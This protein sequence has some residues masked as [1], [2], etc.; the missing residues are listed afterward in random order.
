M[1]ANI[2]VRKR[3][4]IINNL[5]I[6]YFKFSNIKTCEG[7]MGL[8]VSKPDSEFPQRKLS[9]LLTLASSICK[10]HIAL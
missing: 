1:T 7:Y 3:L 8:I 10:M 5:L 9:T 2:Y 4:L 6:N